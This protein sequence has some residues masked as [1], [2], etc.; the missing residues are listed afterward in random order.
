MHSERSY[1]IFV[2]L[3]LLVLSILDICSFCPA[4]NAA[5]STTRT[6]TWSVVTTPAEGQDNVIRR[7]SEINSMALGQGVIYCADTENQ[8]L[9]RS[10]NGGYSFT[11]ISPSLAAAGAILPV[12]SVALAP[13]DARFVVA[14]TNTPPVPAPPHQGPQQVYVSIDGG[15]NW[16]SAGLSW[17]TVNPGPG[18]NSIGKDEWISCVSL[19]N[20]YGNGFRDIAIGTRTETNSGQVLNLKYGTLGG[21]LTQGTL[22][23]AVTSLKFSPNYLTD[24]TLAVISCD[25]VSIPNAAG[26]YLG[27]RVTDI[28]TTTWSTGTIFATVPVGKVIGTDLAL[29]SDFNGQNPASQ[30]CFTSIQADS[31]FTD[32]MGRPT[33][34]GVFYI[35]PL[36]LGSPFTITPLPALS[37][38]R[39]IYSIAYNGS[40][41]TGILLAGEA[42]ANPATAMVPVYQSSNAQS[43]SPGVATW[44][45][46]QDYNSFKSPTGGGNT[47]SP[48]TPKIYYANAILVW[49]Y[50]GVAYCGTSSEDD[51]TGGT[52][53]NPGQ[54]PK[55]KLNS[56]PLDESAFS[57]S[58]NNG[59]GWNQIGL[60]DT[61]ISQLSD[62]AALEPPPAATQSSVLYLSS[63][64]GAPNSF[65]SVWRSTSDTL[66]DQ[67]ERILIHT[68]SN[69][70]TILRV[71]MKEPTST[72]LIFGYLTTPTIMYTADEGQK[73]E[74]IL[75]GI[76]SLR[77]ITFR[78]EST[79]YV[80][81]D[82]R[83]RQL[84]MGDTNWVPGEFVN[85]D[86]LIPAHTICTPLVNPTSADLV[87]VGSGISTAG[88]SEAYVAWTD[89][90]QPSPKFNI[91]RMLP[92]SGNVHVIA[93]S[94]YDQNNIIYAAVNVDIPPSSD[95]VIYRWTIGKSTDWDELEPVNRAF[96]GIAMAGDVL[97]GA[98]N[99]DT[100]TLLNS[101]GVD[102]TLDPRIDVPP[103][104]EWDELKDGL[105]V[106]TDTTNFPVLFTHEPTS[107]KI[108]S[109]TNNTLWAI[110]NL[111]KTA[112]VYDFDNKIGCLWQYID[113]VARVSP[114][115]IAPASG[116]FIGADP[117]TGRSQ[118]IDIKWRPLQD[119]FGYDI[120]MAK[121]VNFTLLLTQNINMFP[122]DNKTGA[123]V[124]TLDQSQQLSPGVWIPPGVL[125]AGKSYYWEVRGS[126]TI[127][128]AAI[129]SLWSP[130]MFFSVKPGFAVRGIG[131]GP[132]L[133]TPID[134][135]CQDCQP[136][137]GF[138]W[139]PVKNA[140]K[141]EFTLANDQDL[142]N[143][144]VQ[145]VTTTTAYKY[146]GKLEPGR[147]YFWRVKAV[148]PFESDPSPTG[149]FVIAGSRPLISWPSLPPS[150]L[151]IVVIIAAAVL[152][153][154]IVALFIYN[155]MRRY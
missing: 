121:D 71:N 98:W 10:I 32:L 147:I 65:D 141:Y 87:F 73:W 139:T 74:L 137:I 83:I 107:L 9:F 16:Q 34:T 104:P 47:N 126:R 4:A 86:L 53:W 26:L 143:I 2:I 20:Q 7:G 150:Y 12:W 28:N 56:V 89:F 69:V 114:W 142:K 118:Q 30:G 133:L 55:S 90:S 48:S 51:Y 117:V 95:G 70:G 113:S 15:N 23:G 111:D 42:T 105:P 62:S 154:L 84:T 122:V 131:N 136:T 64:N 58:Y 119:I 127:T 96:F 155:Y 22:P 75:A 77:D 52:G 39:R 110:D 120:L 60:I 33:Q 25:K 128:G 6:L 146:E 92:Q 134:G 123:W 100:T 101:G 116:S 14:V 59:L 78:D 135:M 152:V 57:Y 91:L 18:T 63:I 97:Y 153:V 24:S 61:E 151:W 80:L 129:H 44:T 11:D 148:A 132:Q 67:W 82:Y 130:V 103:A 81:E 145:T 54:W 68:T 40:Q 50:N 21:W 138:S 49:G 36:F 85:T 5:G 76:S 93:D 72:A 17:S 19:S 13:D 3:L 1:R 94:K 149:T 115:P 38:G 29:P 102:R 31:T 8:T 66:G 41:V 109:S 125:E 99:F 43:S 37:P 79:I 106:S 27:Q 124:V 112:K 108:S 140:K 46:S 35:N 45:S 144:L 88:N